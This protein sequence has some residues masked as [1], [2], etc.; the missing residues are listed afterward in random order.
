MLHSFSPCHIRGCQPR[1]KYGKNH[2]NSKR[3]SDH[4]EKWNT[5]MS[6]TSGRI[7]WTGDDN[8]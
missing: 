4:R 5:L 6:V 3:T 8:G 7:S 2:K 1:Q